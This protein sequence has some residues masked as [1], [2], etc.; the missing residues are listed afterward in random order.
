LQ[1]DIAIVG[2]GM[3]GALAGAML[4]RAGVDTVVIDPHAAYPADFRCEK[5]DNSQVALLRKTGLAAEILAAT[6]RADLLTI[7][8]HG[9]LVER[10]PIG[11]HCAPYERLVNET[12]KLVAGSASIRVDKVREIAAGADRQTLNL[13]SG[14]AISARL[15]VMANGL[16]R[17]LRASLGFAVR[18]ISN[19][20]S[21]SVGFD[22]A[23][24]GARS[25]PFQA[26]TCYPEDIRR[27]IAYLSIFPFPDG[28]RANLFL[29]RDMKDPFVRRLR[30][31]P[32]AVL[33][34]AF[35]GIERYVGE[36]AIP[37]PPQ[38]RPAHLYATEN[39][40]RDG[41][42]L[43]GDA[44]GTSCPAAG[45]GL[46]KVFTDVER[47]CNGHIARWLATPGMTADKIASFYRDRSKVASDESSLALAILTKRAATENT[48]R[49]RG[50]RFIRYAGQVAVGA[51]REWR[52]KRAASAA[53]AQS[54]D[55]I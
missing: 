31:D 11:Q 21:L 54:G 38:I 46:N 51:L 36:F 45:T 44:F 13:A 32:A 41:V 4:G 53:A 8:R 33:R 25:F 35:P 7:C 55:M 37:T 20:H 19:D 28:A 9:R 15:V 27:R 49:W 52:A 26:L 10:R 34:L 22:M 29:Y 47:L 14:A 39:L 16:N 5:L 42:V 23:P 3:A 50:R 17:A 30:E 43:V 2:G 24:V 40:W 1:T 12:R 18:E 48:L 6:E